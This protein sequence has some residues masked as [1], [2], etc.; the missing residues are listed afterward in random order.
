MTVTVPPAVTVMYWP[1][2]A[3]MV[4]YSGACVIVGPILVTVGP[5]C[6]IVP[7]GAVVTRSEIETLTE[8]VVVVTAEA[9]RVM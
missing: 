5:A 1:P 3:V 6:V 4:M 2:P 9:V 8:T 7:P